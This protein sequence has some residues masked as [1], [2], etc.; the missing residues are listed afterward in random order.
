MRAGGRFGLLR[1]AF[2]IFSRANR[3]SLRI[4][5][6]MTLAVFPR[7]EVEYPSVRPSFVGG[8]QKVARGGKLGNAFGERVEERESMRAGGALATSG[9]L[10][11][12]HQRSLKAE[13]Q[14]VTGRASGPPY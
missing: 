12:E 7:V 8:A 11:V 2:W 9:N 1:G 13:L 5:A 14:L 3:A 4:V 10:K 6:L